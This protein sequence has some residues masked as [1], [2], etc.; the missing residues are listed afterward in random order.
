MQGGQKGK[1]GIAIISNW[2]I[3]Y[4]DSKEDKHATKRA[5]DFMYGW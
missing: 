2:M 5:L 1:I 3:P 4:E